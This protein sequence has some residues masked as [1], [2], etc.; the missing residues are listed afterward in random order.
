MKKLRKSRTPPIQRKWGVTSSY[1]NKPQVKQVFSQLQTAKEQVAQT[2]KSSHKTK[3]SLSEVWQQLQARQQLIGLYIR[4]FFTRGSIGRTISKNI[5]NSTIIVTLIGFIYLIYIDTFFLI[6]NV[7]IQFTPNSYLE[8]NHIKKFL[9]ALQS[10]RVA[11]IFPINSYWFTNSESL[12]KLAKTITP[13]IRS[14][15]VVNRYWPNSVQLE[16]DTT[17]I[18]ATVNFK[19]QSYILSRDGQVL[20]ED[21]PHLRAQVIH[22]NSFSTPSRFITTE[23]LQANSQSLLNKIYFALFLQSQ[24][25]QLGFTLT[26]TTI[27][28][29]LPND[30]DLIITI[31]KTRIFFSISTFSRETL[32]NRINTSLKDTE[33]ARQINTDQIAYID[34]RFQKNMYVCVIDSPCAINPAL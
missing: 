3:P 1:T 4:L 22:I 9:T 25:N 24:L 19:N 16:I 17:P 26:Q 14:V 29:D 5:I 10:D 8:E 11:G 28:S 34:M 13:D 18:V 27:S 12:T 6:R 33:L 32:S 15:T 31:G 23:S 21:T 20:G 2:H 7:S 30:P